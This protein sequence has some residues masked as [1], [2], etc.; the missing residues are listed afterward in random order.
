EKCG[1]KPFIESKK[2]LIEKALEEPPLDFELHKPW[3]D[4]VRIRCDKC[5]STMHREPFV[6]DTW[7]NSG[8]APYARF[9]DEEFTKYVPV[10]FLT[11]GIDQTRGWANSLLLEHVILTGRAEAPY[12]AFLFQGLTQDAKGRKMSKS[13]GNIIEVNKL[14]EKASAD[15][16]RF[17]LLRKCSPIDFMN[18][19]VNEMNRRPY[20]VL[21]TFYHLN[22]F[23]IQNAEYDGFNP[24]KHTLEWAKNNGLLK[25]PDFWLLS[26]LQKAISNCTAMLEKC[27]F[28]TAL[29][30]LEEF[31]VETVS[32]LYVPMIRRELWT[33]DPETLNRRLAIYATLWHAL[34]TTLLLF[35]PVTPFLCEAL[36]QKIYKRLD[37]KLPE[38]INFEKW[39]EPDESLRNQALEEEF[40]IMLKCVSLVY[41]A[42]Q[43]AKLKRRWPLRKMVVVASEKACKAIQSLNDVLLE[44]ANVKEA[45]C[46]ESLPENVKVE[47]DAGRWI[48]ASEKGISVYLDIYR[49]EKLLG[50]GL[51]RDVARRIQSLRKEL[52]FMPTDIL[53][54]VHVAGLDEEGMELLKPYIG[55]MAELVRAK[56][57]QL[58][59]NQNEVEAKW[60]EYPLDDKKVYIAIS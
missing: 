1:A 53:E 31:V 55:E 33:D 19:D 8:A 28:N 44:L 57:V 25:K 21:A 59:K 10:A 47:V 6:L 35:N 3:I 36:Y 49:D 41:S 18:F 30:E 14:L 5:G 46:M 7:H 20:Q 15:V 34:K 23:F 40:E 9:T 37:P 42:R 24:Q 4:R 50:E 48:E 22:R 17:Y 58:H 45:E 60:H 13:L 12:K 52:G 11:E 51:M 56:N 43:S 27:E 16:C 32:R 54:T 2:E 39:P 38:S 26:K 29:A